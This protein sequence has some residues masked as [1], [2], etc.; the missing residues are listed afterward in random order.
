MT[1]A[2]G[3]IPVAPTDMGESPPTRPVR[4]RTISSVSQDD[5]SDAGESIDTTHTPMRHMPF[6]SVRRFLRGPNQDSSA[7]SISGAENDAEPSSNS[8]EEDNH[9]VPSLS[10]LEAGEYNRRLEPAPEPTAPLTSEERLR[11]FLSSYPSQFEAQQYDY[12]T[13]DKIHQNNTDEQTDSEC[14]SNSSHSSVSSSHESSR[15]LAVYGVLDRQS[16]LFPTVSQFRDQHSCT[17]YFFSV[18]VG[19]VG[20]T[21]LVVFMLVMNLR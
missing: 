4:G 3:S 19:V 20:I 11:Y 18:F 15:Y 8:N 5:L 12:D 9:S 16:I 17:S 13:N 6:F 14:A 21:A 10:S 7:S 2:A 1:A